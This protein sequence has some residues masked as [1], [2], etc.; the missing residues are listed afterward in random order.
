MPEKILYVNATLSHPSRTDSLARTLLSC[1][2]GEVKEH[3]LDQLSLKHMDEARIAKRYEDIE[4]GDFR[5]YPLAKDFAEADVIVIAAPHYDMS[6][7]S[8]LKVYIENIYVLGLVTRFDENGR[9]I[10]LCKAKALYYVAT[11]GGPMETRFGYEYVKTLATE[12]FGI[13]KCALYVAER[14]DMVGSDAEA[15]LEEAKQRIQEDFKK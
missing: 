10:G 15:I 6:F 7:P 11:S 5:D 1:L 3:K 8:L 9:S 2:G 14:L 4:K 13:P 12:C